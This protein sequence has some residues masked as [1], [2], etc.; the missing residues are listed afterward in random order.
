MTQATQRLGEVLRIARESKGLDH[1]RVERDTKIRGRYLAALERGE[2]GELPG[3]VYAKG[4]LRNYGIYLGLD[5]DRLMELYRRDTGSTI[6]R[7]PAPHRPRRIDGRRRLRPLVTS[8]TVTA[9]ALTLLVAALVGWIGWELYSFARTPELRVTDPVGD[10][11]RHASMTYTVR[12]VTA[13][14]AT[15]AIDGLRANPSITARPD[16]TFAMTVGLVPGS[17]VITLVATDPQTRRDSAPQHRTITVD[18]SGS[19]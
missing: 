12:G 9:V 19:P 2:Y 15:I 1:A 10:V 17:N 16:G 13:P 7:Q 5:T 6:E 8:G 3:A 18:R 4:F 11:S 14:N